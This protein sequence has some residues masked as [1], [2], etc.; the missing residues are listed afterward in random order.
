MIYNIHS[1]YK[2]SINTVHLN[3][4]TIETI[5][6]GDALSDTNFGNDLLYY[7]VEI[8]KVLDDGNPVP[9]NTQA[10]VITPQGF[11]SSTYFINAF[12]FFND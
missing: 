10:N 1:N 7:K 2:N 9:F 5:I 12:T 8:P 4:S 3:I 11:L 6:E